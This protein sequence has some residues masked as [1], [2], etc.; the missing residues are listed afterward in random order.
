MPSPLH[1]CQLDDVTYQTVMDDTGGAEVR[2]PYSSGVFFPGFGMEI[3]PLEM[4]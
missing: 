1:W 4:A 2:L 3:L